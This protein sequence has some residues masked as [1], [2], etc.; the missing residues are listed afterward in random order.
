MARVLVL[1][2]SDHARDPRVNRQVAALSSRHEVVAAGLGAAPLRGV[3]FVDLRPPP[4][5]RAARANQAAGL[6]RI[7]SRRFE[8]AYW[9]NRLVRT[10]LERLSGVQ[11][12]AVVA[13]D[14]QTLPLGLRAA[15]R[16]RVLF[17]AHEY[18][19]E[20]FVQVGWWRLVMAPYLAYLCRRYM[21]LAATTTTV[22][23]GLAK[24]YRDRLGVEPEVIVN[25]PPR[26]DL[27]PS[28]VDRPIR[29][30]HHGLADSR[31]RLDRTIEAVR[32]LD[33]R[34]VL[35]LI[36]MGRGGELAR[37]RAGAE[38]D[39]RIRF[40]EPVPLREIPRVANAY[41]V[42]VF[43]LEP[44]T[45]NQLHV[46]PNK[47]FEFI[48]ARLAVAIGP[49]PDMAAV[50]N[51]WGCGVVAQEFSPGALAAALGSLDAESIARMKQR[52]HAAAE[53]LCAERIQQRFMEL[54]EGLL[55]EAALG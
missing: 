17:D 32:Q 21:P 9:G 52:S 50:V 51:D 27:A 43:M 23:P 55:G 44:R 28:P 29:L 36:L 46:L 34:F 11:P 7:L 53:E 48:Q 41:D 13:N 54:V 35:D 19:P 42:G 5:T 15:G 39:P 31:R 47:L 22:S 6:Q 2:F 25:A 24:L 38:G 4:S 49:S 33:G 1:S 8:T 3:R 14:I 26:A 45:P 18:Y 37:L 30:L 20:H 40:L 10:S 16:A 12:D